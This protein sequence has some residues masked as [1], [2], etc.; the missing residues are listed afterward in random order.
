MLVSQI[1]CKN[2]E[3]KS[4]AHRLRITSYFKLHTQL[5]IIRLKSVPSEKL[6]RINEALNMVS[7]NLAITI[8]YI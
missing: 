7:S 6:L 2:K 4:L 5:I 8:A 3:I 1:T